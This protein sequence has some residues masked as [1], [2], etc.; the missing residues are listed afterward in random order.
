MIPVLVT[1]VLLVDLFLLRPSPY[2]HACDNPRSPVWA[3]GSL[4]GTGA[5]YGVLVAL[6]QRALGGD[7]QGV[8]LDRISDTVLI[9]GNLLAGILIVLVFHGGVTLV[10]W[11]MAR[12]VGGPGQLGVLYRATAYLMPL[13]LPLLPK[14]ALGSA[15]Q[16]GEIPGL[17]MMGIY[18]TLAW[19]GVLMV[20]SGLYQLLRIT[21]N[22]GAKRSAAAVFLIALFCYAILLLTA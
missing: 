14:M 18:T 21:Q 4:I 11:L 3:T 13:T 7:I 8:P 17:P 1:A 12:A 9:G 15:A 20:L 2:R 19:A 16:E 5:V 22:L 6:F 10:V